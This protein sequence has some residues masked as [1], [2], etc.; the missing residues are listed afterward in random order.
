MTSCRVLSLSVLHSTKA[1]SFKKNF[2]ELGRWPRKCENRDP[3]PRTH[4]NAE[5][6]GNLP[7]IPTV[8]G[9]HSESPQ[10]AGQWHWSY[11][12]AVGLTEKPCLCERGGREMDQHT[13]THTHAS[14]CVL[15]HSCKPFLPPATHTCTSR[16]HIKMKRGRY[17][18]SASK[19]PDIR[20]VCLRE[21]SL[22]A[23]KGDTSW[24]FAKPP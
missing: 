12:M 22:F 24:K 5:W 18:F 21:I 13:C 6:C 20:N 7:V 11:W 23:H 8:E 4:I 14:K 19:Y 16:T 15:P 3:V 2:L 1:T 10:Q 17:F 9:R